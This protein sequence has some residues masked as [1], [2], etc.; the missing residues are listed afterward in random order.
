MAIAMLQEMEGVDAATY[1]KVNEKVGGLDAPPEGLLMHTA[2]MGENGLFRI[3]D[4]WESREAHE[5]FAEERLRP[6]IAEV[7]GEEA[8]QQGPT[9]QEFYELHDFMGR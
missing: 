1:D 5:K 6:A 3:F 2:G 4:V 9:R 7:V 8:M